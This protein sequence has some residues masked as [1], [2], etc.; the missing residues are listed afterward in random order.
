MPP[1]VTL[2]ITLGDINGIGPEVALRAAYAPWPEDTRLVLI[3]SR[4]VVDDL[5][6]AAA[7][8]RPADWDPACGTPP[9]APV[10][11]WEPPPET[12]LSRR[13]GELDPAA[14][15]AAHRWIEAAVDACLDQQLQGMITAPISK[16]GFA[17]AGYDTPGHTELLAQRTG[18][19]RFAM[20]LVGGPL[21]VVLA[22]RHLPLREVADALQPRVVFEAVEI[23]GEALPWLGIKTGR[24][25]VCGL[26]PHAG[27][28]GALGIEE[29]T[30]I[31]PVI[32]V[33]RQ[34]GLSISGPLPADTV[35]YEAVHGAYDIVVAMYH[36]QGLGPLKTLAFDEGVNI[37]LGLP[38]VR[39]SP[40]HG[41]AFNIAGRG[42]ARPA[43]MVQAIRLARE[44]ALRPNPWAPSPEDAP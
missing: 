17:R 39:T 25:A 36:D 24:I 3:G 28:G 23:A 34:C 41:T 18:T 32:Q 29:E 5:A 37:T 38:I 7:Q 26:N 1:L 22:T 8:S 2:G 16:E 6:E 13:P 40:D 35:F 43:S 14:S 30:V 21:R 31:S 42:L 15:Q 44:L 19:A 11:V 4:A 27:D 9:D 10:S 12:P 20:L 33:L